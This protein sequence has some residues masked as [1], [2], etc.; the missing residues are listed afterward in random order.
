MSNLTKNTPRFVSYCT[1][2]D[3]LYGRGQQ[4]DDTEPNDTRTCIKLLHPLKINHWPYK[5]PDT[6][7]M[8]CS[9]ASKCGV[10][11]HSENV[12]HR[13]RGMPSKNGLTA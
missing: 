4:S 11:L 7:S 12:Y 8:Y 3:K 13:T 10:W 6:N 9:R 1:Y 5:N 2:K